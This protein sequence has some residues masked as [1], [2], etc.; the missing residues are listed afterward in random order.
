MKR[1]VEYAAVGDYLCLSREGEAY[2]AKT[3]ELAALPQGDECAGVV[4]SVTPTEHDAAHGFNHGYAI[5]PDDAAA[6]CRWAYESVW[7]RKILWWNCRAKC[8]RLNTPD[9]LLY[10]EGL[11]DSSVIDGDENYPAFHLVAHYGEQ[12]YGMSSVKSFLPSVG[13]WVELL[14]NLGGVRFNDKVESLSVERGWRCAHGRAIAAGI[15]ARFSAVRGGKALFGDGT[16]IFWSSTKANGRYAYGIGLHAAGDVICART[17]SCA[18][19]CSVRVAI[20]F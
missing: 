19:Q 8:E 5:A 3:S 1:S 10:R 17:Y 14:C 11:R 2:I 7:E 4:F 18:E 6:P 9:N 12:K 16:K 20:A 15:D 13:Q